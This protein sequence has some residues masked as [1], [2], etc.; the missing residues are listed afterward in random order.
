MNKFFIKTMSLLLITVTILSF[1]GCGDKDTSP[2]PLS[3]P[4]ATP[5]AKTLYD[6]LYCA[7]EELGVAFSAQQESTWMG[8]DDYE[9][10]YIFEKTGKYPAIRGFDYMND[11]FDGVN[12]RAI[13]WHKAG[14]FVTIC[15]HCGSDFSGEWKD[16]MNDEVDDWEKMLTEGTLQYY[17]M[18][19][20][21]DKA[22]AALKELCDLNIP[23]LWRPFHE[24]DGD[25]FWWSKGGSENFKKLWQ[26]MYERFTEHWEL[27]NLIWVLGYSHKAKENKKWYPGDGYC[28]IIG[29]DTYEIKL[30]KKLYKKIS[31]VTDANKPLCLHECGENPT[32]EDFSKAPWSYFMTWHTEYLTDRNSDDTL[33]EL[34]N[35]DVIITLDEL[36]KTEP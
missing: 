35:S 26:I 31:N 2:A 9:F 19:S 1:F 36:H 17:N 25:W 10:S 22:A 7:N 6:L 34:Y 32:V 28:D 24:F 33:N 20:G 18:L 23:V 14:G 15:W 21:M 8:S 12:K 27:D 5:E 3:N 29:A 13:K 16:C 30:N 11:D 4:D